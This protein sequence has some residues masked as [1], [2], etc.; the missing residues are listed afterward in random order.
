MMICLFLVLYYC[1]FNYI[2][3]LCSWLNTRNLKTSP[4]TLNLTFFFFFFYYFLV[5]FRLND[6]LLE[7]RININEN[8]HSFSI[9]FVHKMSKSASQSLLFY[10]NFVYKMSWKY[11]HNFSGP[12]EKSS[13]VQKY[14]IYSDIKCRKEKKKLFTWEA[15]T[16]KTFDISAWKITD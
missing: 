3:V 7:K 12:K 5:F 9:R 1:K 2:W 10:R 16:K 15:W 11:L 8:N 6:W 14:W 13:T 4:S